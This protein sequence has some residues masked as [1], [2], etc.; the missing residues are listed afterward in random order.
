MIQ[1]SH[2]KSLVSSRSGLNLRGRMRDPTLKSSLA[3]AVERDQPQA[4][5]RD[6]PAVFIHSTW[7]PEDGAEDGGV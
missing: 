4:V 6:Q 1:P 5:E 7:R 3:Q 2:Q